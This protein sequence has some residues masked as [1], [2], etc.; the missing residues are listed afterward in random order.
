VKSEFHSPLI[1]EG[2]FLMDTPVTINVQQV[3]IQSTLQIKLN[4]SQIFNKIFVCGA[5]PGEDWTQIIPTQWGYQNISGKDY[6]V[7][8]PSDGTRLTITNTDGDWM[9]FNKITIGSGTGAVTIIPAN[10]TWGSRQDTY[11]IT[12]NGK[13]TDINGDPV[14]ALGNLDERLSSA[15]AENIPV[16]IQEYGVYNKTP[17]DVTLGYLT[18]V[19][20]VFKKY[21]TGYAM[22][23]LT[24]TIGIIN[25]ERTDMT[26]ELYRGKQ[27]DREMLT[28]IQGGGR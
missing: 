11:R 1:L 7:V 16:M 13:I 24:G 15:A 26:Y 20:S 12:S 10:T 28:I 17:H 6:S 23:N 25:S 4:D 21:K 8:L 19:V 2:N 27:L 9:T 18:D 22:W 14:V 3:S 5:D